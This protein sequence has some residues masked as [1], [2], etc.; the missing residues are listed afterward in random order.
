MVEESPTETIGDSSVL[1]SRGSRSDFL[2]HIIIFDFSH[3]ENISMSAETFEIIQWQ[4]FGKRLER[5]WLPSSLLCFQWM[6]ILL[7]RE[8][9]K[10]PVQISNNRDYMVFMRCH[11]LF[12]ANKQADSYLARSLLRTF[13]PDTRR[14]MDIFL[15]PQRTKLTFILLGTDVVKVMM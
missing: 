1:W 5:K 15:Q 12:N 9:A 3:Y 11:I 14:V 10:Q 4:S 6:E 7:P 8:I 13:N 2:L